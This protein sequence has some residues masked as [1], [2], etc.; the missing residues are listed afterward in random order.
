MLITLVILSLHQ[1]AVT[2][3][4][5][6]NA[7]TQK[8]IQEIVYRI[9]RQFN[10]SGPFNMQLIAKNNQLFVIEC[11]LRVSRSFPFVS[12]TLD[13][14]FIALATLAIMTKH[15]DLKAAYKNCSALLSGKHGKVGVKVPMFSFSRL[16]GADAVM[17]VEVIEAL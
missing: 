10:V 2:P 15:E 9:A 13:Y 11:N 4:Q 3:P 6:L 16:A 7:E 5:D 8:R 1:F 17:G 12:K 14:D